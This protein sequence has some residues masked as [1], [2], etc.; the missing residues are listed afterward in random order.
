MYSI[1]RRHA[2]KSLGS[3]PITLEHMARNPSEVARFMQRDDVLALGASGI[4]LMG[5][6]AFGDS[7]VWWTCPI[8]ALTGVLCPGCGLQTSLSIALNGDVIAA[9]N[10]NPT[11][12]VGPLLVGAVALSG[13]FTNHALI[14]VLVVVAVVY[15]SLFTVFRNVGLQ[16]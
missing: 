5:L 15:V 3:E 8:H 6:V 16:S 1:A 7:S 2:T 11:F 13:R 14:R 9:F 4:G 10:N 12:L